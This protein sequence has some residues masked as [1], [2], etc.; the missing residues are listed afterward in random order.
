VRILIAD[1]NTSRAETLEAALRGCAAVAVTRLAPGEALI[2]A[3]RACAPDVVLVDMA[4]PD[5]TSLDDIRRALADAPL[6]IV[7]FVDRDDPELM[8][9]AIS[10]GVSSYNV[11][12][13]ASPAV[14]PIIGA[15]VALFERHARLEAR[16]RAAEASLHERRIIE[17]AKALLMRQRRLSEPEAYRWLRRRA[18]DQGRR[19][20]DIAAELVA[21]ADTSLG[22]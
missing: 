2:D 20:P 16:L 21:A 22:S 9:A 7:M 8:S 4:L 13:A 12:A 3:I 1:L 17:R 11:V 19:I 15:A 10:A 18:M 6:P 5:R 14:P